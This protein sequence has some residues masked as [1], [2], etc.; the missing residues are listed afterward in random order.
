MILVGCGPAEQ[1]L[2]GHDAVISPSPGAAVETAKSAEATRPP[3]A[4]PT[5]TTGANP[6]PEPDKAPTVKPS[7]LPASPA[8]PLA[9]VVPKTLSMHGED[10]E[11]P[12]YWLRDDDR[13][14]PEMLAQLTAENVYTKAAMGPVSVIEKALFEELKGRIDKDDSTVPARKGTHWYYAEFAGDQEYPIHY[15]KTG[16]LDAPATPIL[17]VNALAKG[18]DYIAV[19]SLRVSSDEHILA[20]AE[21]TL[22]RRVYTI[23]FKDLRTGKTLE[24]SVPGTTGSIAWADDS[25]T[26]FY[27][28]RDPETL[29]SRWV[30]RHTLGSDAAD[31]VLVWDEKD[32]A[33][34]VTVRQ[35]K[36]KRFVFIDLQSTITSET[37]YVDAKTPTGDSKP[38]LPREKG[39]EYDVAHWGDVF[40]VRSNWDAVNFRLLKAPIPTS[41]DKATW[42]EVVPHRADVLV[43]GISAFKD[44]LVVSERKNTLRSLHIIRQ[45]DGEAHDITFEEPLYTARVGNN[46]SFDTTTLRFSYASPITP[47]SVYD[48][49][50]TARTRELKKQDTVLG[51]YDP[52]NYDMKREWAPSRDGKTRIPVSLVYR[53]GTPQDGTAPVY[54]YGYGSYGHAM[55][56]S[57]RPSWVSLIDRGFVVA[58]AHIRGGE[59]LGRGW[60][61]DGKMLK[62]MN[63]FNDFV[64]VTEFLIAQNYTA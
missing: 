40:Y 48:Y 47:D 3:V 62:K 28:K 42:V 38:V 52:A 8:P 22:S 24:D 18:H 29:R 51:G 43:T 46:P 34:Y 17:D 11:D 15:R 35:T 19:T 50:L 32:E 1:P 26:L 59:E 53:K 49:D 61:D 13:K 55:D 14:N 44:H 56:P 4:P 21:D 7:L 64:D 57:F 12:Y 41:G 20:Y 60:Y 31:D 25:K 27:V 6:T 33:Y 36:S 37:R 58:I 45:S 30:Y 10:R 63:T 16:T 9:K 39:H 2:P 5:E 54:Q 23:R